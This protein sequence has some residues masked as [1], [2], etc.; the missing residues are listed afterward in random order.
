MQ[1]TYLRAV[2]TPPTRLKSIQQSQIEVIAGQQCRDNHWLIQVLLIMSISARSECSSS[3][4]R[5]CPSSSLAAWL[6]VKNIRRDRI[7]SSQTASKRNYRRRW[8]VCCGWSSDGSWSWIFSVYR[9]DSGRGLGFSVRNT[10]CHFVLGYPLRDERKYGTTNDKS[11]EWLRSEWE[12][13]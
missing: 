5:R 13:R 3:V 10:Q 9:L 8:L 11:M 12:T 7:R 6:T 4:C 2:S 1:N